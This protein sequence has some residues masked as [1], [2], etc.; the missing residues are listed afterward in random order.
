MNKAQRKRAVVLALVAFF[1]TAVVTYV[2]VDWRRFGGGLL[3]YFTGGKSAPRLASLG[4]GGSSAGATATAPESPRASGDALPHRVAATGR[5]HPAGTGGGGGRG[6]DE[7][8]FKYGDP[9]A[10]G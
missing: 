6:D 5:R 2:A 7:D 1:C 9:A 8:L 10:G 3:A 4:H